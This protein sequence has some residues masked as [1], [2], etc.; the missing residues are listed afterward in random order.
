M[1]N[2]SINEITVD[3]LHD[4][5]V[6]KISEGTTIEFKANLNISSDNDKKEFLADISSFANTNGGDIIYGI[7]AIEG[8]A[9]EVSGF[10]CMSSDRILLQ[11]ESLM[12]DGLS[13]RIEGIDFLTLGLYNDYLTLLIRIPRSHSAPHQVTLKGHDKYYARG[14]AGKYQMDREQLKNAFLKNDAIIDKIENYVQNRIIDITSEVMPI[15]FEKTAKIAIH[16]VPEQSL[17]DNF[18]F[19]VTKI[20]KIREINGGS[21]TP[22][23]DIHGWL[24][25]SKAPSPNS[26][27]YLRVFRNGIIEAVNGELFYPYQGHLRIPIAKGYNYELFIVEAIESYLRF[28]KDRNIR[29]PI[30]LFISFIG[31]TG[32][33]IASEVLRYP[34]GIKTLQQHNINLHRMVIQSY[35]QD[36]PLLLKSGFDVIWNACGFEGSINYDGVR[37]WRPL[38]K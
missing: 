31:M 4:L 30:Y 33:Y 22:S 21:T 6:N 29:L 20:S 26:N 16:L 18:V 15:K 27:N 36:V 3:D 8:K 23:Y 2:K 35:N 5:V 11:L 1:I 14:K 28:Y 17:T 12:R 24:T 7:K 34:F 32:Y 38:R 37:L 10:N 25:Y 9:V 19:D 13:P